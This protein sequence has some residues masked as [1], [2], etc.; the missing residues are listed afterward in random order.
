MSGARKSV[1]HLG[2]H[3]G[4]FAGH[5]EASWGL[6]LRGLPQVLSA[7]CRVGGGSGA[8]VAR[9][10]PASSILQRGELIGC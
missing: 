6:W 5:G 7:G 8:S 10:R 9:F 4:L 1:V 2:F 3:V